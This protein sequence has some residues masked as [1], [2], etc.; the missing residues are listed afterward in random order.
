MTENDLR[1][2]VI[3]TRGTL[4]PLRLKLSGGDVLRYH[5]EPDVPPQT[6]SEHSW[7]VAII[8]HHLWPDRSYLLASALYHDVAEGLMGDLPA[9]IKRWPGIKDALTGLE[10]DYERLLG[11]NEELLSDDAARL[12]C[13]DYLELV[14]YCVLYSAEGAQRVARTGYSYVKAA[15]ATLPPLETERVL[16]LLER[17]YA[18]ERKE[19]NTGQESPFGFMADEE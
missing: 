5:A 7:R 3:A 9:P 12:K 11:I 4:D 19:D 18:G 10:T 8:L 2:L 6:V 15:S 17:F 16:A 13:A 14:A 1:N